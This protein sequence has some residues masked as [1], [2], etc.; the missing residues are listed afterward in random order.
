MPRRIVNFAVRRNHMKYIS[1]ILLLLAQAVCAQEATTTALTTG[2]KK[3]IGYLADDKLEGRRTGSKGERLAYTYI[4]KAFKDAGLQGNGDNKTFIQAFEVHDGKAI[5][6]D[7]RFRI[8]KN[9]LKLDDDYFPLSNSADGA[10]KSNAYTVIDLAEQLLANAANPHFDLDEY[11]QTSVKTAVTQGKSALLL[12]N[13]STI[14]DNLSFDSKDKKLRTEIPVIYLQKKYAVL[15]TGNP[16]INVNIH[17]GEKSRTGHN[18]LGFIDNHAEATI[19]LGAHYD[20]LGYGEDH[21]SLYAGSKPMIHNGAD[22]NASGTAALIELA[23]WLKKSGLKKYNYQLIAFSGEELGLFGSKYFTEHAPYNMSTVNYMINMDMIGRLNDSTHG[24]SIGGYGT[25]PAWS[26]IMKPDD[27]F[28]KIRF[29]SSGSGPSDHTSFYRK[30]IPVLFF[31]TGTHADYHK[32]SDD[33]N[34]INLGG[35]LAVINYIKEII[36]T[37][38]SREKLAFTKTKEAAS[39]GKNSFKVSLGIMP[40]YTFSG[41]GVLVDGVSEGKAA[42]KAGIKTGDVLIQLGE[43]VFTDVQSY[44]GALNKF[45]KGES[46]TVKLKRGTTELTLPI[47]F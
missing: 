21:N 5:S 2:L 8:G 44:M 47:T 33:A 17:I 9:N 40:D 25:S 31:F 7:S 45:N 35:E 22:D 3:H 39:S 32:P 28:F 43:H 11:I 24:L 34:K 18:V 41:A 36:T 19:I 13:N 1:G 37:T 12:L 38:N 6:A 23:A 30:D 42:Q 27:P 14:K 29:D 20:H 46:T 10:F 15:L 26:G 4:S 16:E